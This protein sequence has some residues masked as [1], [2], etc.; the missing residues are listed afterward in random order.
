[1]IN[2]QNIKDIDQYIECASKDRQIKQST[3][4][5]YRY[6]LMCLARWADNKLLM[7]APEIEP[8]FQKWCEQQISINDKPFSY[9][10]LQRT[11]N[12]ARLFFVWAKNTSP[13]RFSHIPDDWIEGLRPTQEA[14]N[15][16]KAIILSIP[17]LSRGAVIRVGRLMDMKYR[18]SEI[19]KELSV[20][21]RTIK[22]AW[23][24]AGAPFERDRKGNIWI[25]GAALVAWVRTCL[26]SKHNKPRRIMADNQAYCL[27]CNQVV[28]IQ[29]PQSRGGTSFRG[30]NM[31]MLYGKCPTCGKTIY[32]LSKKDVQND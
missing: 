16:R 21:S 3:K 26:A 2:Q 11:M 8:A 10:G 15:R 28:T 32:R 1:M 5:T 27:K 20:S 12:I 17:H 9:E 29:N 6:W 30:Q 18:P 24:P 31:I 25:N 19:A 23:L 22:R 13:E 7:D 4:D 14:Q